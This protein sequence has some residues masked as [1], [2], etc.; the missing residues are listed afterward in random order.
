VAS[1]RRKAAKALAGVKPGSV[2][3]HYTDAF[4]VHKGA[5]RAAH[6]VQIAIVAW[7]YGRDFSNADYVNFWGVDETTGWNHRREAR[8]VYGDEVWRDVAVQLA[9]AMDRAGVR[10]PVQAVKLALA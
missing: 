1:R 8:A 4:G 2:L 7:E 6:F 3:D 10:S 5:V 9:D